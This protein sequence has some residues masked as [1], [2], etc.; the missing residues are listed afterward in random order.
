MEGLSFL[1]PPPPRRVIRELSAKA[2]GNLVQRAP[3]YSATQGECAPAVLWASHPRTHVCTPDRHRLRCRFQSLGELKQ[4]VSPAESR[5]TECRPVAEVS[6]RTDAVR[7]VAG[8]CR[9]LRAAPCV[10]AGLSREWMGLCMP[11]ALQ[12]RN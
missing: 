12:K 1:P 10:G 9:E 3:G 5:G 8:A 4:C 11:C 7:A 6:A 2:L